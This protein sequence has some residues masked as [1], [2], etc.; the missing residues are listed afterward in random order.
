MALCLKY[1]G[2]KR[3]Q[4]AV[5]CRFFKQGNNMKTQTLSFTTL[6]GF[7]GFLLLL[8]T[9]NSYAA[10]NAIECQT[11]YGEKTFIIEDGRIA[12]FKEDQSGLN[13][14]ISSVKSDSVRTHKKHLGF[15]KT[16]YVDGL[17]HKINIKNKNEFSDVNDYLSVTSPKGHEM[18]YPLNCRSV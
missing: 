5:D 3:L 17:K 10:S 1:T 14:S 18:T 16:L 7:L 2:H 8:H 12:F 13:R 6:F 4:D 15:T 9:F 11:G